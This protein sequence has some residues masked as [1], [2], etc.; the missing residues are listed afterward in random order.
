MLLAVL[1][2]ASLL[3]PAA[4]AAGSVSLV[5]YNPLGD[6]QVQDNVPLT[7]RSRLLDANGDLDLNGKNIVL[8][9]YTKSRNQQALQGLGQLLQA[10][11]P[12]VNI[13]TNAGNLGSPWNQKT[14]ANYNMWAGVTNLSGTPAG[15]RADAV[16]FGVLD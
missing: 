13:I 15:R 7:D 9:W 14:E 2:L 16:I 4:S 8:A 10:Q 12:G 11:F 5:A 3:V 6:V 1:L